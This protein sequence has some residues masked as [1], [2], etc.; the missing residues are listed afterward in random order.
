MEGVRVLRSRVVAPDGHVRDLLDVCASLLSELADS[1]R[2]IESSEST[3]VR[4]GDGGSEVGGDQSVSVSGVADNDDL[5][6]LLGD[7]IDGLA[8]SLENL[9][10]SLKK[11]SALHSGASGTSTDKDSDID[12]LEA[13]EGVR[14]GNDLLNTGVRAIVELHD[15]A[16]EKLLGGGQLNKL[17]DDLLVRSEHSALSNEVA[18][19]AADLSSG[20]GDGNA[21]GGLLE[22]ARDSGEVSAELLKSVDQDVVLHLVDLLRYLN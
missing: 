17:K 2:L 13:Y 16:L 3:E 9:G 11:V 14:G 4:L 22:V 19:E 8:L 12:V 10:V 20:A 7:L 6:R 1:S 15:E 5:G 18:K 21:N